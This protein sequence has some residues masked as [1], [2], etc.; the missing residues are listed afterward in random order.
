[1]PTY[2]VTV[3]ATD[4]SG[5][6]AEDTCYYEVPAAAQPSPGQGLGRITWHGSVVGQ[7]PLLGNSGQGTGRVTKAGS[8]VGVRPGM[9]AANSGNGA[10]TRHGS[11]TGIR[12][13]ALH[14]QG[15]ATGRVT[16]AGNATGEQPYTPPPPG[17]I[18]LFKP[19]SYWNTPLPANAPIHANSAA[20]L[21]ALYN[22]N[23]SHGFQISM[24]NYG[25]PVYYTKASDPIFFVIGGYSVFTSAGPGIK[26][27]AGMAGNAEGAMTIID[28]TSW[29]NPQNG[30]AGGRWVAAM[31]MAGGTNWTGTTYRADGGGAYYIDSLGLDGRCTLAAYPNNTPTDEPR[32]LG[33]M[34]G[35]PNNVRAGI[36]LED[37]R[38]GVI[39][40]IVEGFVN[41][42]GSSHTYPWIG[43]ESGTLALVP[44]GLRMRLKAGVNLN[45]VGPT[46]SAAWIVAKCLQT[47]GVAVGDQ[48]GG[49]GQIKAEVTSYR[50]GGGSDWVG[51]NLTANCLSPFPFTTTFWEVI[52]PNY[53]P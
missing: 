48:S 31:H 49:T 28:R 42:T 2:S 32:N 37:V 35:C 14:P 52:A 18:Q 21:Q 24:T 17:S 6:Y 8:A 5:H 11:A 34:R 19:S 43:D 7:H 47:Y 15:S 36:R 45:L 33:S 51:T 20:I 10:L 4:D 46:G 13:P 50:N 25:M 27:P 1:M 44:E 22:D 26:M 39:A 16:K 41:N 29:V 30:R 3:V 9:G 53:E 38:A 12:T 40:H 23:S